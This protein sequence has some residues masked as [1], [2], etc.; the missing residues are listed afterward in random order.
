MIRTKP[1]YGPR[2]DITCLHR[3]AN[4]TGADQPAH[5]RSLI[6]TFVIQLI[7]SIIHV[8]RTYFNFLGGLSSWG[9]WFE[10]HF[11]RHPE[12]RFSGVAAHLKPPLIIVA[13]V[14]CSTWDLK[15]PDLSLFVRLFVFNVLPT[16]RVIRRQG[17]CLKS[18]QT[19]LWSRGMRFETY[20]VIVEQDTLPLLLS[21]D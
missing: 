20:G 16:A 15:D 3:L 6:S 21:T 2:R 12:D 9:G 1:A 13:V 11:V 18:H 4:N 10:S 8:P 7:E 17:N 19:D 14:E 5:P